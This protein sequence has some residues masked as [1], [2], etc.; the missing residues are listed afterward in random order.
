[1][2]TIVV[3]FS[4]PKAFLEPFSWIIRLLTWCPFS[5]AY[6]R[7]YNPYAQRQS[8]FQASGIAVNFMS[9][10]IFDG[11]ED[12]YAEFEIPVSEAAKLKTVQFAIDNVGVP[13]GI[14]QVLGFA[15]IL[16]MRLFGKSV[17]NPFYSKNSFFCSEMVSE[18][19]NEINGANL[20]VSTM[21]PKDLYNWLIAKGYKPNAQ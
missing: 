8:V 17:N 18:V 9:Q 20:D 5:H 16:S 7:Y 11:K 21:T 4:R 3:G 6:I 19:L 15:C 10:S 2:D 12:I 14:L 1:M 13:Y